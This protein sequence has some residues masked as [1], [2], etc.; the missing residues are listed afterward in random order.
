MLHGPAMDDESDADPLDVVMEVA[1]L[2]RKNSESLSQ[3]RACKK[4][5]KKALQKS[6]PTPVR[7][8]D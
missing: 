3:A 8:P 6:T 7:R 5:V 4:A 2:K 1:S